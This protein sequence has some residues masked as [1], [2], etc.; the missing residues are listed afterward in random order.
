MIWQEQ[1]K[2]DVIPCCCC[3]DRGCDASSNNITQLEQAT[4][5][6][7]ITTL[8]IIYIIERRKYLTQGEWSMIIIVYTVTILPW[9]CSLLNC[10]AYA[11]NSIQYP[12][13][14]YQDFNLLV[15]IWA[16]FKIWLA[17]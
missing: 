5:A 2:D 17:Q 16:N 13:V 9:S 11:H 12:P 14:H 3:C 6:F 8:I 7:N 4:G 15:A 1:L 10:V